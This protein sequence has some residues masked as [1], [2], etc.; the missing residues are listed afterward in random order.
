MRG[1]LLGLPFLDKMDP[2]FK[3]TLKMES[4]TEMELRFLTMAQ[5]TKGTISMVF[6]TGRESLHIEST[7]WHIKDNGE[8]ENQMDKVNKFI[9]KLVFIKVIS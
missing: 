6:L 8:M 3:A 2:I 7:E 4:L 9:L 1:Y 5:F